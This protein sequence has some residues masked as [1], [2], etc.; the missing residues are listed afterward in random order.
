MPDHSKK[1]HRIGKGGGG[2]NRHRAASKSYKKK[3]FIYSEAYLITCASC[4]W[5]FFSAHVLIA[6]APAQNQQFMP[7]PTEALLI[8]SSSCPRQQRRWC[9]HQQSSKNVGSHKKV[10]SSVWVG[11]QLSF[12]LRPNF[13]MWNWPEF[14]SHSASCVSNVMRGG[15]ELQQFESFVHLGGI[16]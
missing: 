3:Y 16:N 12:F 7:M 8:I 13:I 4:C 11:V 1:Q 2:A 14:F 10:K 6:G 5:G 9:D 15:F